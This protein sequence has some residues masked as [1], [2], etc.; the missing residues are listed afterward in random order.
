MSIV[1]V[2]G[3]ESSEKAYETKLGSTQGDLP[4]LL[5]DIEMEDCD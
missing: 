3:L 2:L 1:G 4:N 5:I